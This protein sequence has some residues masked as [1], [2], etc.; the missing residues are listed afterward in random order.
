MICEQCRGEVWDN[1]EKNNE[2]A[3]K[4]EKLR[5]DYAC[6]DKDCGW[7]KW[8]PKEK[9]ATSPTPFTPV[10]NDIEFLKMAVDLSVKDVNADIFEIIKNN[11]INLKRVYQDGIYLVGKPKVDE[12]VSP[13]NF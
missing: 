10:S 5:P 8:R 3:L 6:K 9:K 4:G 11:F 1:R 2:R 7:V 13:E 12:Q